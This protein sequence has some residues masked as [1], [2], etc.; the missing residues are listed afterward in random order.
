M[1]DMQVGISKRESNGPWFSSEETDDLLTPGRES[2]TETEG[3]QEQIRYEFYTKPMS[4]PLVILARSAIPEGTKVA[5]MGYGVPWRKEVLNKALIGYMRVLKKSKLGKT[6]RNRSGS[7]T[8]TKRR[9]DKLC[10]QSDW[11]QQDPE[12]T[13]FSAESAVQRRKN[14][15]RDSRH[16]ESVMFVPLCK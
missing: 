2:P 14:M 16:V 6:V 13:E 5:A 10:G 11:Y 9:Y 3:Q 12:E 1:L 4:N 15:K 8:A 7:E